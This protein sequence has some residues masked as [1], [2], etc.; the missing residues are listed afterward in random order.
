LALLGA[1]V[2]AAAAAVVLAVALICI[3]RI[4]VRA[5]RENPSVSL[6]NV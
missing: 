2:F 4:T 1:G 5:A 6:K 3:A